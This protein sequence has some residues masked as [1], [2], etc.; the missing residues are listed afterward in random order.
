MSRGPEKRAM[1]ILCPA[2]HGQ[3]HPPGELGVCAPCFGSGHSFRRCRQCWGLKEIQFMIGKRG[4]ACVNCQDCAEKMTKWAMMDL[5]EREKATHPRRNLKSTGDGLSDVRVKF[6]MESS[7]RKT[8]PIPVSMTT[9]NTCPESCGYY[10]RGCYAEG[11][12]LALHWRR[13]SNEQGAG[14][15]WAEFLM[16]VFRVPRGQIWRHNEAGDLPGLGE[17]ID[18]NMCM[19]LARNAAHT[20]GFTYT[21]KRTNF[22]LLRE[23]NRPGFTVNVSADNVKEADELY[24]HGL[25]VAVVLPHDFAKRHALT[26]KGHTI[27]VCPAQTEDMITC[28]SCRLCAVPNRKA[29]VGFMAHGDRKK[30]ISER[31]NGELRLPM[32]G[33]GK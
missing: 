3:G 22:A 8:G 25:P 20:R 7:N 6:S 10:G 16:A 2:C 30:Q 19:N 15:S 9:A 21:H 29:I 26:P 31:Q 5:A 11:H 18:E 32:F 33:A 13:L 24:E 14:L 4:K 27:V 23:M 28:E 12:L 1:F 17:D